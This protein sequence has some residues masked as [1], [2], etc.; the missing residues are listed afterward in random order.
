MLRRTH[1]LRRLGRPLQ[2]LE[3]RR[4]LA[5]HIAGDATV[6]ATIQAAVDAA[7]AGATITVDAGVYPELVSIFKKLTIQGAR[8]GLDGRSNVRTDTA[9]ES[10]VSGQ[11]YGDG[12]RSSAF[13]IHADDVIIDGFTVQSS[14]A[15]TYGGG[16][17]IFGGQSGTQITNNVIQSNMT[18]VLLANNSASKQAVIRNNLFR[19]NNLAGPT[20]G[21]AIYTNGSV[22]GGTL[23]NVLIDSNTFFR[24]KD[25]V[26]IEPAIG[27][28]SALPNSQTNITISNNIFDENGKALL[29][30][31]ASNLTF[32]GNI[33]AWSRDTTS[34]GVRFEGGMS[35]VLVTGNTLFNSEARAIRIDKQASSGDNFN[36]TI[37]G[38][39]IFGNGQ[40]IEQGIDHDGLYIDPLAYTGTLNATGNWWGSSSGPGGNGPGTGDKVFANGNSVNFTGW[41]TAPLGTFPGTSVP[42]SGVPSDPTYTIEA[43]DYDLGSQNV[44]Y[45]DTTS[46]NLGDA[47]R[48]YE[49]VDVED[50][51]DGVNA[52]D[53]NNT[54]A[55]EWL[56][57]TVNV[58]TAG[59]YTLQ[60]RVAN[61]QATGGT[62]HIDVGGIN[63][64]G[65]ITV[66]PTGGNQTWV[67]QTKTG[68]TLPAGLQTLKVMFDSNPSGQF[69]G[70]FNWFKFVWAG[71]AAP[72]GLTAAANGP[73]IQL[74][75]TDNTSTETG[76]LI[77][78]RVGNGAWQTLTTTAANATSYNDP[79]YAADTTYSYRVR[80]VTPT[81]DS[82]NSNVAQVVIPATQPVE[83][84]SQLN[85]ISSTNGW[86]P[87]ERDK[88]NGGS[89][90]SD[91]Q[92]IT[93][94]GVTYA[95]GVGVHASE[96]PSP[97]SA[98][99]L[100]L[101]GNYGRFISDVGVDD[102]VSSGATVVFQVWGDGVK[103][104]DS[105]TM[106]AS[107]A[108]QSV[109]VNV[110]GVQTLNLVITDAGDGSAF[111]HGDWAGA[112][113]IRSN[114]PM[115]TIFNGSSSS[116]VYL[117]RLDPTM[118]SNVEVYQ[119]GA[120]A[121]TWPKSA[122]PLLTF[123][124]GSGDDTL[125]FDYING[126][127]IPTG[128]VLFDGGAGAGDAIV[129]NGSG[130]AETVTFVNAFAG[131]IAGNI[132]IN[133]ITTGAQTVEGL[134]FNGGNGNDTLTLAT[135]IGLTF[136]GG[137][138]ASDQD[139]LNLNAGSY[140]FNSDLGNTTANLTLNVNNAATSVQFVS[141][142]KLA[143][144]SIASSTV[145]LA[146][147]GT[148]VLNTGTLAITGS[149]KL[150]LKDNDA[151]VRS[152]TLGTWNGATA[153]YSG[154][155]GLVQSGRNGGLGAIWNGSGVV[156]SMTSAQANRRR[157][158]LAVSTAASALN[159]STGA[160]TTWQGQS[161]T[162]A[163]IL[164][165][166]TWMGDMNLNGT[167][168]GDDYFRIDNGYNSQLKNYHN[169]DLDYSGAINAD[170]YFW[171]DLDYS[172]QNS[173]L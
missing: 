116:D 85:W 8:S 51:T 58:P 124:T 47:Y 21:R 114:A 151:V 145:T 62:F 97:V 107:T 173:V 99:S 32:S 98:I 152:G 75:W 36:F 41:A 158:T 113:L 126:S 166:Y 48:P 143:A 168:T 111:D 154:V 171:L 130:L 25:S 91:G 33:A 131:P 117:L 40:G 82:P 55:T 3:R 164:I 163:A 89:N 123:N 172:T 118:K 46:A 80:A 50:S 42:Y 61:G 30:Y 68:V 88:S 153:T 56:A 10:I 20:Q 12:S 69:V 72:T 139:T 155:T 52:D 148:R 44:A 7:V 127:P 37:T 119:G 23:T 94:N 81:G 19:R 109:S 77:E 1:H 167:I 165:K 64:S 22:S 125:T 135:N 162:G 29:A 170:D 43:E 49:R 79:S 73:V 54:K 160:S 104:F 149:G 71:P 59:P 87:A 65:T 100:N 169:G 74:A 15:S 57:Y 136:N 147:D 86:G 93:L 132:A 101:G 28:E 144:L 16:V 102:E 140:T 161:I 27:L 35:N 128:G 76:F 26:N 83:Y 9:G 31:N 142:Q 18:G 5:A 95:R 39:N 157:T 106:R 103:L 34:A 2:A 84:V 17:V 133:N 14:N 129:I 121:W 92:I 4:F 159:I 137:M 120:L 122:I 13:Y 90:A 53:V 6:Y 67:T 70:S 146:A 156:T 60:F 108:T 105:G 38:N 112:R 110:T 11:V 115:P 78:R 45:F 134:T 63:R 96:S 150:D 138:L 66:T 24:N 141:T